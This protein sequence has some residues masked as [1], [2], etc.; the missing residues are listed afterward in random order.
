M[1]VSLRHPSA[2]IPL[3][4]SGVVF[5]AV[6]LSLAGLFQIAP[7]ILQTWII[8]EIFLIIFFALKWMPRKAHRAFR[9]ILI[10]IAGILVPLA[11]LCF[12]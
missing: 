11:I 2:C 8:I 12:S 7:Y 1:D 9:I 6:L 5:I 3:L 4:L 10:Q